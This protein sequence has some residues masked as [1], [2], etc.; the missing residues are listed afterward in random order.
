[1]RAF[2]SKRPCS[3]SGM[4]LPFLAGCAVTS[5]IFMAV[6]HYEDTD[7]K[8]RKYGP[9][10]RARMNSMLI[11]LTGRRRSPRPRTKTHTAMAAVSQQAPSDTLSPHNLFETSTHP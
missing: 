4:I 11:P 7:S 10:L 8:S 6:R 9:N 5:L 2:V 1:M 3:P